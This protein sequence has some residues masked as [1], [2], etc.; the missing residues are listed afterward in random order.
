[1]KKSRQILDRYFQI[2]WLCGNR[3]LWSVA[4]WLHFCFI[5]DGK[6]KTCG[7]SIWLLYSKE[8][9]LKA[10]C[11]RHRRCWG[12]QGR[13][14]GQRQDRDINTVAGR[15]SE[16]LNREKNWISSQKRTCI[17]QTTAHKNGYS[18]GQGREDNCTCICLG[19]VLFRIDLNTSPNKDPKETEL[20]GLCAS[21]TT[22]FKWFDYNFQFK[23]C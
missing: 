7:K 5:I 15:P 4:G 10:N 22:V 2:L 12:R 3:R 16:A 11:F 8:R 20:W 18:G 23:T 13:W 14:G 21:I 1:M 9:A 6:K 19:L 17:Q